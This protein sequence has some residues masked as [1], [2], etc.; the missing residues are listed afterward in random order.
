MGEP[1]EQFTG[2]KRVTN[3]GWNREG[4]ITIQQK[5]PLPFTLLGIT[6]TLVTSD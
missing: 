5:Q 3:L 6:G 4:Q 1:I 2:D